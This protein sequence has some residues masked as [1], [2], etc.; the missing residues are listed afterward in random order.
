MVSTQQPGQPRAEAGV[1]FGEPINGL[2]GFLFKSKS[3]G[4]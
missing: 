1:A 3:Q 2:S 4:P